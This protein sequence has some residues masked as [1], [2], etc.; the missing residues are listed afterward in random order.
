MQDSKTVDAIGSGVSVQLGSTYHNSSNIPQSPVLGCMSHLFYVLLM[1]STVL[2]GGV[3]W[4]QSQS[5]YYHSQQ[6]S[7]LGQH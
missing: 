1:Q 3:I 4:L 7:S 5:Q 6:R 2:Y